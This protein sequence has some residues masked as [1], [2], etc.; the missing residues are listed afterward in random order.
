VMTAPKYRYRHQ[1]IR[2]ALL[3]EAYGRPCPLCGRVMLPGQQLDLDHTAD[4]LAYRGMAH[5]SC[6]R[7]EG[8]RRGAAMRKRR[9]VLRSSIFPRKE[10]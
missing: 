1:Q 6:N 8:A 4:G 3:P 7:R 2:E 9:A 10:T 5:A